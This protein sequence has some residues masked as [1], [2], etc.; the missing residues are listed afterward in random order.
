MKKLIVIVIAVCAGAAYAGQPPARITDKELENL[1]PA[2]ERPAEPNPL[3]RVADRMVEAQVKL[4]QGR[5]DK[6]TQQIQVEAIAILE[7]LIEIAKEQQQSSRQQ[8]RPR[9]QEQEK[10]EQQNNQ[11]KPANS[12]ESSQQGKQRAQKSG[13]QG[14]RGHE[15]KGESAGGEKGIEWGNLPPKA[16][17]EYDQIL[18]EDFPEAYKRLLELYFKNL[19][20]R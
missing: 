9:P 7:K 11:A 19:S 1:E 15:A 17:E 10:Q 6:Q 4:K 13:V 2:A 20:D 3:D 8:Q 16:R 5:D 18:K 14:R 12:Q